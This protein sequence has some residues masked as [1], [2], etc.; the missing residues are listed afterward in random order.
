MESKATSSSGGE[1][2]IEIP[3]GKDRI[4]TFVA[5][6][7][8]IPEVTYNYKAVQ[9]LPSNQVTWRVSCRTCAVCTE[10]HVPH[11]AQRLP[12]VPP[13]QSEDATLFTEQGMWEVDHEG[14]EEEG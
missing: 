9:K 11:S 4:C 12:D 8:S 2:S 5:S 3:T 1:N 6:L 14:L 13:G 10:A 7:L